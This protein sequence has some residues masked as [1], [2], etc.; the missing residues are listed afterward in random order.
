MP[1][2]KD[3]CN[4]GL[5]KIGASRVNNLTPPISVL[6]VKC[7]GE[8]QQWKTSELKKRRWV[9]ATAFTMLEALPDQVPPDPQWRT[10]K[11]NKPGDLLRPVRPANC[12]WVMR[13][14][15]F[16][17]RYNTI[18]LEYIR[19]VEDSEMTDPCFIDVLAARVAMECVELATQSPGKRVNAIGTYKD[20]LDTASRLNA[21]VLDPHQLQGDEMGYTWDIGRLNP[22]LSGSL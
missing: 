15:F 1:T 13:G 11:F 19:T 8:Y 22:D 16:Y 6:E 17:D 18:Q 14:E 5:G 3:V 4:Q 20:A 9:F 10:Y 7:A 2:M 21:F 12:T